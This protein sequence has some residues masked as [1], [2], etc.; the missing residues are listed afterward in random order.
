MGIMG[1]PAIGKVPAGKQVHHA[2]RDQFLSFVLAIQVF[3]EWREFV[4]A[5]FMRLVP[6]GDPHA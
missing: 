6:K 3:F 4:F 5:F 1:V 2:L